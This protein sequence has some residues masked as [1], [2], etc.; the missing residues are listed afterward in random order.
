MK[1]RIITILGI[2]LMLLLIACSDGDGESPATEE[3]NDPSEETTEETEDKLEDSGLEVGSEISNE[4]GEFV[5]DQV[6]TDKAEVEIDPLNISVSRMMA[7][8]GEVEGSFVEIIGTEQL[9]YVQVDVRAENISEEIL[10]FD[11]SKAKMVT[12]TGEE[13]ENS[14]MLLSDFVA[15]EIR[16]GVSLHGS[17][18]Y[19]LEETTA[20][21]IESVTLHWDAPLDEAGE[22]KGESI[23]L[24]LFF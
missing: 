21:E 20:E 23:E 6:T 24:E 5:V 13:I 4:H 14:D 10:T 1:R 22:P 16:S 3:T 17:F 15:D 9:N 7:V 2:S 11:M 18:I 19:I 8:S 12:D